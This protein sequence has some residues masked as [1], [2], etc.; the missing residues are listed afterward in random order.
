MLF[1]LIKNKYYA[2]YY[3]HKTGIMLAVKHKEKL[4][5][6]LLFICLQMK[7]TVENNIFGTVAQW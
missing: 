1:Q 3:K 7:T 2:W 5:V 4:F 6:P